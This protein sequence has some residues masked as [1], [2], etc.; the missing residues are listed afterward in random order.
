ME[1]TENAPSTRMPLSP[2]P[3]GAVVVLALPKHDDAF[4]STPYQLAVEW[5]QERVVW[6]VSH[7]FTWID[8]LKKRKDPAL[9]QR[10]RATW[11]TFTSS[12]RYVAEQDAATGLRLLYLPLVLPI[13]GLPPGRLYNWLSRLNHRWVASAIRRMVHQEGLQDYTFVNSH[14]FYFGRILP[15]LP[16]PARSVYHCIDPIVKAYSARHGRYLEAEAARSSDLVITTSPYLKEKMTAYHARV[17]CV[18][19]AANFTLSHQTILPDTPV[20][21]AVAA[22]PGPRIGYIGNIERRIAYDWLIEIF[23]HHP[24]WQLVMVGPHDPAFVPSEFLALPNVWLIDPV[25][26]HQLP[27]VLKGFDVALIPFKKDEVSAQIYPLKLFE[28]M[29]SG[30]PVVTTDFNEEVIRPFQDQV[31]L[32][33]SAHEL[34]EAIA[35]ALT[36]TDPRQAE[37]R[38]HIASQ[39]DWSARAQQFLQLLTYDT[40][41]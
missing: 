7:P 31:Y 2:P 38:I 25:P 27:Q 16:R 5:A 9:R 3:L 19:N 26:H 21:S 34:A 32:G 4:T 8:F 1:I 40:T 10:W 24:N 41:T 35:Q 14:D 12:R 17:H 36:E 28:Y 33:T 30:K 11:A 22:V 18:P 15:R 37:E 29:G 20:N 39:N 13:N 6:Y 23:T